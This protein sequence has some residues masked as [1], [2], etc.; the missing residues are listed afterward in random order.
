[1][2]AVIFPTS[3]PSIRIFSYP[4]STAK[5]PPWWERPLRS[6]LTMSTRPLL[7][8]QPQLRLTSSCRVLGQYREYG[9]LL[10]RGFGL[11][12]IMGQC[13][14]NVEDTST[15]G[16]QMPVVCCAISSRFFLLRFGTLI[17]FPRQHFASREHHFY[18]I[19]SPLAT[20]IPQAAGVGFA[21][22][23]TPGRQ[24]SIAICFM[25]EG[26]ASE[27]GMSPVFHL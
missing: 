8:H 4:S 18:S 22:R 10:W 5:K 26:A 19:S 23:R 20:Q 13:L 6:S 2:T 25:G 3:S 7:W 15:K 16:R 27:G 24:N 1:M 14:G 21:L 17:V 11:D 9:V 12:N